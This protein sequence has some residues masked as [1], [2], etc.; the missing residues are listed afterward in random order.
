MARQLTFIHA[1][2]LHIG[3]PFR[4]LR[5]LSPEWADRLCE[6]IPEAYDRLIDA[7]VSRAVDFVVIA[8]DV[9]DEASAS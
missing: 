6:A 7:A 1:A 9:F 3:A 5:A 4:G 2:D 8:G